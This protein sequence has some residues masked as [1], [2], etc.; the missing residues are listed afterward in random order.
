MLR[1]TGIKMNKETDLYT[2]IG[3]QNDTLSDCPLNDN[4][5]DNK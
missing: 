2:C 3:S 5:N 4:K 1:Q